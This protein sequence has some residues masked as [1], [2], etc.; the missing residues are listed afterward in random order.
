LTLNK[1][2]FADV[3]NTEM[4]FTN[5]GINVIHGGYVERNQNSLT[6]RLYDIGIQ[7]EPYRIILKNTTCIIFTKMHKRQE[8]LAIEYF[9]IKLRLWKNKPSCIF[10]SQTNF[11]FHNFLFLIISDFS[12]F[13]P[14]PILKTENYNFRILKCNALQ[15]V[16]T[17]N[18]DPSCSSRQQS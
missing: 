13:S 8:M 18:K 16:T 4:W 1:E 3:K 2:I 9:Q 7:S 10:Y 15:S 12:M 17:N 11:R 5:K 14:F 6:S